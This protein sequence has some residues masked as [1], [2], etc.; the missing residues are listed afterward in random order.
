MTPQERQ[1]KVK[2][3]LDGTLKEYNCELTITQGIIIV[4][5]EV[6]A[7]SQP[8]PIAEETILSTNETA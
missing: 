5:N 3:I 8:A 1:Q 4:P 7:T 6:S 2:E